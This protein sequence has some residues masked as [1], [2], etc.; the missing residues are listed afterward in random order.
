MKNKFKLKNKKIFLL[1]RCAECDRH[2]WKAF[3]RKFDFDFLCL[4]NNDPEF[5][6]EFELALDISYLKKKLNVI[7]KTFYESIKRIKMLY[8]LIFKRSKTWNQIKTGKLS[9]LDKYIYITI[10]DEINKFYSL[11]SKYNHLKFNYFF[12]CIFLYI[13]AC[14]NIAFANF[15]N[16]NCAEIYIGYGHKV[17]TDFILDL[18][19]HFNKKNKITFFSLGH[20]SRNINDIFFS[21][22]KIQ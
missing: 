3:I 2:F 12:V 15:I 17:Y 13:R 1:H 20:Y 8:F 22:P 21:S 5:K 10:I 19:F 9:V 16:R 14:N 6:T 4:L 7:F 18:I 11:N